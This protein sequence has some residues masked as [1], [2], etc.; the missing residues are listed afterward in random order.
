MSVNNLTYGKDGLCLTEACEGLRCDAYQDQVG[1]WTIGYGHT[2]PDVH[3]GLSITQAIA[4]QLLAQDVS[5]AADC[6]NKALTVAVTQEE[7][8][9]LV[10]FVYNMGTGAFLK[11]TMLADLNAGN[12][13]A[14]AAQFQLWDHA[15]G[16]VVAGLLERRNQE[17][18]LFQS[19]G[20][21]S[22]SPA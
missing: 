20:A 7:F 12:F 16:K 6:V 4:E 17:A 9:A 14:A 1:V 21:S 3:P 15:G 22:S 13:A 8:D 5:R 11:S 19:A 2:G 10:D 18:A